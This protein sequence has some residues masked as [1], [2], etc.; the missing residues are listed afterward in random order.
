MADKWLTGKLVSTMSCDLL[1]LVLCLSISCCVPVN[2][3]LAVDGVL[4]L[5][6][7]NEEWS[8]LQQWFEQFLMLKH[9]DASAGHDEVADVVNNIVE[10]CLTKETPQVHTHTHT[11]THT[12]GLWTV[13]GGPKKTGLFFDSL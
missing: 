10:Q 6:R 9:V 8:T 3:Q 1:N 12:N 13:Q 11:H 4:R 7:F 2:V 5:T